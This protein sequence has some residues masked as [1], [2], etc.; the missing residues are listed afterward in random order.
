[1]RIYSMITDFPETRI[2]GMSTISF[3]LS[4]AYVKLGHEVTAII[5][6][7]KE[8]I[9][10]PESIEGIKMHY[11]NTPF[12]II[13]DYKVF[14]Y[15]IRAF[16]KLKKL[17]QENKMDIVHGWKFSMFGLSFLNKSKFPNTK[18]VTSQYE[19]GMMDL[20][21]KYSEFKDKASF[22]G[23]LELGAG[24]LMASV[25]KPYLRKSDSIITEDWNSIA[26]MKKMGLNTGKM[27]VIPNGV[28]LEKFNPKNIDYDKVKE[29]YKI[30]S[31]NVIVYA[32]RL[33]P[34]KGV[35]YIIRAMPYIRKKIPD[36][37]LILAGGT[38]YGHADVLKDLV[39]KMKL[40]HC[41][42]FTGRVG[43][44]L[45]DY[46]GAGDVIVFAPI[47]EGIPVTLMEALACGK[48]VICSALPGIT[49]F[50]GERKILYWTKIRNVRDIARQTIR[51]LNDPKKRKEFSEKGR[52]F[53]EEYSWIKVAK[54]QIDVFKKLTNQ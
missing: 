26:E 32:G 27:R 52:K 33:C 41:I 3:E 45:Q 38:R 14:T 18:F 42:T 19:T 46:Y 9:G 7:R 43:D 36:A 44:N 4:K 37:H 39:N 28:D 6:K 1:M 15:S 21:A 16:N 17:N 54:R 22:I 51:L 47:S 20:K 11:V 40:N 49:P 48:P 35:Q 50:I 23:F 13:P 12:D 29:Q 5:K 31:K 25:E 8:S 2:G 34:R 10:N 30:K 24:V 53:A